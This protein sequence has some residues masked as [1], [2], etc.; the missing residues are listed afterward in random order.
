M[1]VRE[2]SFGLVRG[3]ASFQRFGDAFGRTFLGRAEWL[4][5]WLESGGGLAGGGIV[6]GSDRAIQLVRVVVLSPSNI[7]SLLVR[8]YLWRDCVFGAIR[9]VLAVHIQRK[10]SRFEFELPQG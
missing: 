3:L 8:R 1:L 5:R 9:I 2:C 7:K 4:V 6:G 10:A